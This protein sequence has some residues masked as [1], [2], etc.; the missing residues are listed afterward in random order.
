M[1][2]KIK[3]GI[4]LG[5][6]SRERE[7]SFAGGRTVYD[8]LD[9]GLFEPIPIFVD[10]FNNFIHL[11][12]RYLYQGSIRDF[13]P[14]SEM[15]P[16]SKF[17]IYIESLGNLTQ[18]QLD[19]YISKV[20]KQIKP[21]QFSELIDF[22]F[23]ALHGLYGEDG[24]IQGLLEWYKIPY[25]GSGLL[26]AALGI[27]KLVQ[28]KLMQQA[29]YLVTPYQVIDRAEWQK[30][31]NKSALFEEVIALLGLPLVVKSPRQG[32]SIGVS[33]IREK[34][35]EAFIKA[36]HG[37]FFI[38]QVT[39]QQW[40]SFSSKEKEQWLIN[41]IDLR[42]GIGLPVEVNGQIIYHPHDLLAYLN[43]Y[44]AVSE[45]PINLDSLQGEETILIESFIAGREFSCI[46]LQEAGGEPVALSPTEMLKGD[47]HF[48]YRA[49]Y[50]PGLVRKETPMRLPQ[51]HLNAIKEACIALF[52]TLNFQVYARID[53]ILDMDNQ[54]YLNDPNTTA[55]MNPSSFLFHQA[56][57]IGLNPSQL[58]TFL[59][60]N[61]LAERVGSHKTNPQA[62]DLLKYIDAYISIKIIGNQ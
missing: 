37:S 61:S 46:V 20:G 53:G 42:S 26:G 16:V 27:D 4:F 56:A 50:L 13:Y 15:L 62:T 18:E 12:W 52:Q 49:K 47:L 14:P 29:G 23:L 59:I 31:S 10:S 44:F 57:E 45:D 35:L 1:K 19:H 55:G 25:S 22:A 51:M 58:L 41:L 5:G 36:I 43:D 7:I 2:N 54:I 39:V 21:D 34:N 11:D 9:K 40:Q 28:K 33:I 17:Q 24:S 48:D 32:S 6:R 8:N 3:V 30:N 60:R 38:E